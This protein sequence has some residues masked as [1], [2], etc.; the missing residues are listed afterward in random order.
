MTVTQLSDAAIAELRAVPFTYAA[1]GR[2]AAGTGEPPPGFTT[3]HRTRVLPVGTDFEDAAERLL[4]WWL[5]TGAGL[6]VAASSTI[7]ELG[8]VVVLQLGRRPLHV[9]APCRVVEVV[10]ETDRRGFAY[11]TLPGHPESGEERFLL[12]RRPDGR[13][14]LSIDA[15]SRPQTVPARWGRPVARWVQSRITERYLHALDS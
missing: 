5:Q 9:S 6:G 2:T 13:I 14:E 3:L 12:R 11:G 8:S 4:S 1:V 15:F 10:E 7:V